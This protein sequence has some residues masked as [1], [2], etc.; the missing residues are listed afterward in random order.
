MIRST[1][2]RE[3]G[4]NHLGEGDCPIWLLRLGKIETVPDGL[5][6]TRQRAPIEHGNKLSEP[7]DKCQRGFLGHSPISLGNAIFDLSVEC[8]Q[9]FSGRARG[10]LTADNRATHCD[11]RESGCEDL[12]Q[13]LDGDPADGEGRQTNLGL[14]TSQ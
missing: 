1:T 4:Q 14:H 10:I 7:A 13:I 12:G 2:P 3:G 11:A 5:V 8:G 9:K 6:S